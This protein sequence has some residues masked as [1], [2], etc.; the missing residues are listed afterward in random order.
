MARQ[1]R[2]DLAGIPQHVIQRGNK[3]ERCFFKDDDRH[4]YLEWLCKAAEQYGGFVHA[5]VLMTNRV[6]LLATGME[7]GAIGQIM[8]RLGRR[9]GELV[10]VLTD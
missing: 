2:T 6:Y 5:Y 7:V 1:P 3:R 4:H 10:P 8:Q 9:Y